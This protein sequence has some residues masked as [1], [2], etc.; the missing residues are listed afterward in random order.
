M[1]KLIPEKVTLG[2][3]TEVMVVLEEDPEKP[4][5]IFFEPSPIHMAQGDMNDD[6]QEEYMATMGTYSQLKCS[7]GVFGDSDAVFVNETTIKCLT[8][9]F[10]EDPEDYSVEEVPFS[11]S[12]N[13]F[14][15]DQDSTDAVFT[16][17]GTGE[18]MSNLPIVL[19]IIA[20]GILIAATIVYF[21]KKYSM[22]DPNDN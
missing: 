13:G 19:F 9:S 3:I 1:S 21:N 12:L 16:F 14:T 4:D 20:L 2:S 18:P 17:E 15:F 10:Q 11:V 6:E 22:P 5:N 7:F 8:P